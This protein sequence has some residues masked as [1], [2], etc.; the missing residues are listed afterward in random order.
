M[1]IYIYV[2][3]Y[4]HMYIYI[5]IYMHYTDNQKTN[6]IQSA[7]FTKIWM[8][9]TNTEIQPEEMEDFTKRSCMVVK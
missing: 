6:G 1:F 4:I 9:S 2:Y 7:D 5:Y 3:I 8:L